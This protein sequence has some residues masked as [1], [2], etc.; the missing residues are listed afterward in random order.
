MENAPFVVYAGFWRRFNA[1]GIDATI[2]LVISWFLSW[3]LGITAAASGTAPL[4]VQTIQTLLDGAASGNMDPTLVAT[5]QGGLK[6]SLLG[7]SFISLVDENFFMLVSALYNIFF[8]CGTWQATP[9]K[10]WLDLQVTTQDGAR[11]TLQQSALR[12]A[13]SGLS[14]LLGGLG[15]ITMFFTKDKLALHDIICNTR[16]LRLTSPQH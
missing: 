11:L 6:R 10:R 4:D 12:H 9:G 2:V 5:A 8:I 13:A 15:Y 7:G 3:Q 1:Y 14:M 16:L